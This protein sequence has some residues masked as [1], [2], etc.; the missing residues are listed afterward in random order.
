MGKCHWNGYY[1]TVVQQ[2]PQKFYI[3]KLNYE[4]DA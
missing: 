2:T 1:I 3:L 4:S